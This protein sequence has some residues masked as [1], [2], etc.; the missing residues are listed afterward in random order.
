MISRVN[1]FICRKLEDYDLLVGRCKDL[2]LHFDVME[3]AGL[4]YRKCYDS[5]SDSYIAGLTNDKQGPFIY[6]NSERIKSNDRIDIVYHE[7][8]H[9]AIRHFKIDIE[10]EEE[11]VSYACDTAKEIFENLAKDG[12]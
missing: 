3:L 2:F 9:H 4:V 12:R 6:L 7:A 11:V 5:I 10:N 1:K 8:F